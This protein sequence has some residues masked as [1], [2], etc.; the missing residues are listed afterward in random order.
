MTYYEREGRELVSLNYAEPLEFAAVD[1]AGRGAGAHGLLRRADGRVGAGERPAAR[2]CS[3]SGC[4]VVDAMVAGRGDRAAGA[5]LRVLAA[6]AAGRLPVAVDVRAVRAGARVARRCGGRADARASGTTGAPRARGRCRAPCRCRARRW[7]SCGRMG[8]VAPDGLGRVTVGDRAVHGTGTGAPGADHH[9]PREGTQ[10]HARAARHARTRLTHEGD[11]RTTVTLQDLIFK[12]SQFWASQGCL[13][14]AAAR[15]RGRRGHL[16][17]RD[18]AARARPAPLERGVRAAVAAAG[19]W[20]VRREPEPAVQA[21]PV[22]GDHEARA[23]RDSAD[24]PA[25]PRGR[26]ASCRASTTSGS[27]R[28]TGSRRRSARGASAGRCCSTASRSRSSPTSSRWAASTSARSRWRSPT[29]SSGSRCSC[30][31]S[32]T[33]TTCSGRRA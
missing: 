19:R 5:V 18:R 33:S 9:A 20:A 31:R 11:R 13:A 28:T 2:R 24:L 16:V 7:R 22:P 27:K 6:A 15:H 25:E 17:A 14:A 21:P 3:G 4:S 26:A 29:G 8:G 1:V 23:R 32:T 12:L 10:V 30:R